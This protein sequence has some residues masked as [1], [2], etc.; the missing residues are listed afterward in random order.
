MGTPE[1]EKNRLP[2][3]KKILSPSFRSGFIT[4]DNLALFSHSRSVDPFIF[5]QGE[6][7]R[8]GLEISP[9]MPR[10]FAEEHFLGSHPIPE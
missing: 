5:L 6:Q 3:L 7:I 10:W 4:G 9:G 1:R 2:G 8:S